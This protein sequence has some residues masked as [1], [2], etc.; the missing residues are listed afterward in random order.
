[1]IIKTIPVNRDVI[2]STLINY[3]DNKGFSADAFVEKLTTDLT[4]ELFNTLLKNMPKID[5]KG[6]LETAA[7]CLKRVQSV[8]HYNALET[9][10]TLLR[11]KHFSD[12]EQN[13]LLM[14]YNEHIQLQKERIYF[15]QFKYSENFE[16]HQVDR[17]K[18]IIW[19]KMFRSYQAF[20]EQDEDE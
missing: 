5:N 1:M 14:I 15:N 8:T 11:T 16:N 18:E 13:M 9:Y 20:L 7:A 3:I 19:E 4:V 2:C 12:S 17:G 10:Q 6:F